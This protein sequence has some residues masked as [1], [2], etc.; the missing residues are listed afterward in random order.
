MGSDCE[1]ELKQTSRL[2]RCYCHFDWFIDLTM[3]K[4]LIFPEILS[5]TTFQIIFK[6]WNDSTNFWTHSISFRLEIWIQNNDKNLVIKWEFGMAQS[7]MLLYHVWFLYFNTIQHTQ[8]TPHIVNQNMF[9]SSQQILN[10]FLLLFPLWS[11]IKARIQPLR[12]ISMN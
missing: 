7:N 6:W 8:K 9:Y 2:H 4:C 1:C 3:N 5:V 11:N 10:M 12:A